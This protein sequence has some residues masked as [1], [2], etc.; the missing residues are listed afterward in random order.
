[1]IGQLNSQVNAS[2]C[3]LDYL[4]TWSN[5]L[6]IVVARLIE[7]SGLVH[8]SYL[9]Q[10]VVAA[11]AGKPVESREAPRSD[12]QNIFFFGR[13]FMSLGILI[14]AFTVTLVALFNGQTTMWGI[15]PMVWPSLSFSF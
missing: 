3:M 7:A 12:L 10:I 14:F 5:Y 11:M 8:S 4:N 15:S 1:M 2:H 9:I 6:T 13:C